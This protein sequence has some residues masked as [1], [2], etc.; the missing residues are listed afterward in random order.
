MICEHIAKVARE[1]ILISVNYIVVAIGIR[2]PTEKL[3]KVYG[4]LPQAV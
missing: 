4:K 3:R 1:M 2:M